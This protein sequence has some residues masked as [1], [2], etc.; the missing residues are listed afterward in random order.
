LWVFWAF[1]ISWACGLAGLTVK[2]AI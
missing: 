2:M 1:L